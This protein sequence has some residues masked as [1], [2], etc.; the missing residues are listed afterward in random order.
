MLPL[1]I[2]FLLREEGAEGDRGLVQNNQ[3]LFVQ[4]KKFPNK[5]KGKRKKRR[6]TN[7]QK[8]RREA[9]T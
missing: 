7:K 5:Q 8:N 2:A 6:K 3:G 9:T 1:A 4:K